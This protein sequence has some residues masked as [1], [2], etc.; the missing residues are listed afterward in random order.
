MVDLT[1]LEE[2]NIKTDKKKE[3]KDCAQTLDGYLNAEL[4][5]PNQSKE[6]DECIKY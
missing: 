1:K 2:S 3:I 6:A 4:L 5:F